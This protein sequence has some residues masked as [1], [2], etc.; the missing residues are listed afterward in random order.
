[1][2]DFSVII[3]TYNRMDVLPEVLEALENQQDA[4][5]YEIVVVDD[6]STDGTGEWLQERTFEVPTRVLSQPN[7]GPAAARNL[8]VRE[9]CGRLVAFLG[10]DT[11]PSAGWLADHARAHRRRPQ[12]HLLAAIGY[13]GWHPRL[14]LTPFLRYINDHG[15]Q[16]GY[17]LIDDPEDVPFNF[18]YTSNLSLPRAALL[19]EPFD[20][21]FPYP[22]WEDIEL[23]YRLKKKGLRLIYLPKARVA[24]DHP[25][26][27]ERFTGR[28]EKAGYCA[29][30]F[31]QRHRD[32]GPF[33][34][35]GAEGPPPSP[36][37]RRQ[38]WLEKLARALHYTPLRTPRLWEKILR[39]Y[40]IQGLH[41]GWRD[42]MS[43]GCGTADEAD[44]RKGD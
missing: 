3:P 41:R 11:V 27:L 2:T 29:V 34:G 23:S 20:L 18:L 14:R 22:A 40:Y 26:D 10:D 32:L 33:L 38:R 15:L 35:L 37:A 13:T 16:F 39:Y 44:A 21:G 31:Y 43:P 4:P 42:R 30:V 8:G 12:V 1:M 19:D 36:S 28:Q 24:H 6:G 5:H 17:A 9:A 25:T 7:Q